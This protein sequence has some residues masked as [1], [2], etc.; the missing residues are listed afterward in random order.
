MR[1]KTLKYINWDILQNIF[2]AKKLKTQPAFTCLKLRRNTRTRCEICSKLT[3]KGPK[4]R[5]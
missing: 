4:R 3:I 1:N 2:P 5:H